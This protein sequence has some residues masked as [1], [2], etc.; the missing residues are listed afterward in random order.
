MACH[1]QKKLPRNLSVQ[2]ELLK[3]GLAIVRYVYPPND[4]YEKRYREIEYIAKQHKVGVHSI[5]GYVDNE[6]YNLDVVKQ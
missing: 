3:R 4:R 1:S 5:E 2:E 6:T